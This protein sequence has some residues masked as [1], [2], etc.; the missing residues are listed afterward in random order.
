MDNRKAYLAAMQANEHSLAIQRQ[1]DHDPENPE[2]LAELREVASEFR[3]SLIAAGALTDEYSTALDD[4]AQDIAEAEATA[5]IGERAAIRNAMMRALAN[6]NAVATD[7][8][9]R[10][11]EPDR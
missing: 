11:P 9:E 4:V 5:R 3:A 1:M 10:G 2:V 7:L 8:F 6:I